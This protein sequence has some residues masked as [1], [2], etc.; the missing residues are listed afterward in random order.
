[1]MIA[2]KQLRRGVVIFSITTFIQK[3]PEVRFCAGSNPD[4]NLWY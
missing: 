1:M 3:K 2:E 4:A